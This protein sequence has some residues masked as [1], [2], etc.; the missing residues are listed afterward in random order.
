[1]IRL[2]GLPARK[3]RGI[4]PVCGAPI[5]VLYHA[6]RCQ[7]QRCDHVEDHHDP[8]KYVAVQS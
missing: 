3:Y 2:R 6:N 1:M 7:N 4:C 5:T 8:L